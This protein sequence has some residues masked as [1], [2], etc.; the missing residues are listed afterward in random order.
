MEDT[1]AHYIIQLPSTHDVTGIA[2]YLSESAP[3]GEVVCDGTIIELDQA[4]YDALT[5]LPVGADGHI[6][7]NDMWIGGLG[8]AVGRM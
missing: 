8:Y 6:D 3:A 5:G 1:M 2:H 4:A 7:N